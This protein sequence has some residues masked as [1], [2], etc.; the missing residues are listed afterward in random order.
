M[1]KEDKKLNNF[2]ITSKK[3]GLNVGVQLIKTMVIK[4][5][6]CAYGCGFNNDVKFCSFIV[7]ELSKE[8]PN[9]FLTNF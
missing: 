2:Y 6:L 7:K 8:Q 9:L 1:E 5:F 4:P 3:V